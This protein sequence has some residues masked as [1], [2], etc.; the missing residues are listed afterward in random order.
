[1]LPHPLTNFEI[2]KY[3]QNKPK[4]NSVYSRNNLP[5]LK[6]EAYLINLDDFKSTGTNWIVLHVYGNNGRVFYDAIFLIALEFNIFQKKSKK[7]W[8]AKIS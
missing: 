6:Y 5:K 8:E 1:M 7:S 3:Y 2:Q 4:F